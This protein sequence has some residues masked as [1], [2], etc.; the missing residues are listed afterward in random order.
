VCK[1]INSCHQSFSFQ[2]IT[3]Y[4]KDKGTEIQHLANDH[5]VAVE[6]EV[7]EGI[8]LDSR[9]VQKDINDRNF[10]TQDRRASTLSS[11]VM[12]CGIILFICP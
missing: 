1:H 7:P 2:T 12:P 9:L 10:L 6:S 4:Q 8:H 5:N 11:P 3:R